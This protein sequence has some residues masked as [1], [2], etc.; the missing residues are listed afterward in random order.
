MNSGGPD[1]GKACASPNL[2]SWQAKTL[3][4]SLESLASNRDHL[5]LFEGEAREMSL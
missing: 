4:E 2:Q 5:L 1:P 3:A